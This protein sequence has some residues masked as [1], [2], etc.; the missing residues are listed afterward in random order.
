MDGS[1][2]SAAPPGKAGR[3]KDRNAHLSSRVPNYPWP[4]VAGRLDRAGKP[5]RR[6]GALGLAP[7]G[8]AIGEAAARAPLP[9]LLAQHDVCKPGAVRQQAWSGPS[10]PA[11]MRAARDCARPSS[12][13]NRPPEVGRYT[14]TKSCCRFAPPPATLTALAKMRA[15]LKA[16]GERSPIKFER[17]RR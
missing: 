14:C 1:I 7:A 11:A 12:S 10:P 9:L 13:S 6:D 8:N 15:E 4:R 2:R 16:N 5:R 3:S 17:Q